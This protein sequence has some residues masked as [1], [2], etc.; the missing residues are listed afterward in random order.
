MGLQ[1]GQH[2]FVAK[3]ADTRMKCAPFRT[4]EP[5]CPK[6]AL[7]GRQRRAVVS[8]QLW[9]LVAAL[10][11]RRRAGRSAPLTEGCSRSAVLSVSPRAVVPQ[12]CRASRLPCSAAAQAVPGGG[13]GVRHGRGSP[14]MLSQAAAGR[15]ARG[16]A[17][18]QA[19]LAPLA[20]PALAG[21][22]PAWGGP[23]SGFF[24][25]AVPVYCKDSRYHRILPSMMDVVFRNL[26]RLWPSALWRKETVLRV[27]AAEHP[28]G[29]APLL[30]VLRSKPVYI[31]A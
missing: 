14:G 15:A 21:R 26:E 22:G 5:R 19:L 3:Q 8:V 29:S 11:Y 1:P 28:C 17:G 20:A 12:G 4:A 6:P 23:A 16:G 30:S 25:T 9:R 7:A 27:R 2:R 13:P 24:C 18:A 10:P 31:V